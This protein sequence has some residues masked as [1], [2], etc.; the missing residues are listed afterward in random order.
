MAFEVNQN[1]YIFAHGRKPRGSGYW[2]FEVTRFGVTV[3]E[4]WHN[5]TYSE[6]VKTAREVAKQHKATGAKVLP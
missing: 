4:V 5:G 2:G 1:V 6:A 3:A